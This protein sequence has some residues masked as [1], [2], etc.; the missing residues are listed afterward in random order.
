MRFNF[1]AIFESDM[2][3]KSLSSTEVQGLCGS[4]VG[5]P[6]FKRLPMTE[7]R[8]RFNCLA[9]SGSD[10]VPSSLSS[11]GVQSRYADMG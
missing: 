4:R 6:N 9:I 1:R 2:V 8:V 7:C 11:A 10:L 5:I 3:P